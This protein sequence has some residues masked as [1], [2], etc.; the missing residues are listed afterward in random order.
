MAL[1]T[2]QRLVKLETELQ[3]VKDSMIYLLSK[4][5]DLEERLQKAIS[6]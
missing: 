2:A 5:N 6:S 4:L 3:Q 1:T